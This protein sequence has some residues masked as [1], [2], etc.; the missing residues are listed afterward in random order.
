MAP[1][2]T[3][4]MIIEIVDES[5]EAAGISL[6]YIKKQLGDK[7]PEDFGEMNP[8]TAK[9]VVKA[10]KSAEAKS[11]IKKAARGEK[12]R[13]IQTIPKGAKK[14]P[15]A[16]PQKKKVKAAAKEPEPVV[17]DESSDPDEEE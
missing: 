7:Y 17:A 9:K 12:W 6:P 2:T 11:L 10:V 3:E 14:Q 1:T 16:K 15:A 8:K 5:L 13:T 4:T